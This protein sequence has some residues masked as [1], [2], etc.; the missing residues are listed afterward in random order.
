MYLG[1][2][3]WNLCFPVLCE[4]T[5]GS[6]AGAERRAGNCRKAEVGGSSLPSVSSCEPRVHINDQHTN[7]QFGKLLIINGNN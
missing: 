3:I 1:G 5:F 2:I 4:R 7:F 6:T